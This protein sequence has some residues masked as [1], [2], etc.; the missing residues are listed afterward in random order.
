MK[1]AF[2]AFAI[3]II[4]STSAYGQD[5]IGESCSGKATIQVGTN[6]QRVVPYTLRFSADLASGYYCYAECKPEQTYP[7]KDRTS[8][9]IKLADLNAG[10]QI[11]K[12]TFYLKTGVL[13]DYQ[14][15]TVLAT[16]KRN[17]RATC[18][19]AVFH[20]PTPLPGD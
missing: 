6:A 4:G 12:M 5:H 7:I 10:S 16:I 3:V 8:D 11:R 13:T 9:P 15:Y 20:Q 14:I 2:G 19:P 1:Y 17:A 18:R